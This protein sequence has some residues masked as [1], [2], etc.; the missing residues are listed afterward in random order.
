MDYIVRD[1]E[2]FS[3]TPT[4][5]PEAFWGFFRWWPGLGASVETRRRL[6]GAAV[7]V[8]LC[9]LSCVFALRPALV[10][11][12]FSAPL[13]SRVVRHRIQGHPST[14]TVARSGRHKAG[15]GRPPLSALGPKPTSHRVSNPREC[16]SARQ[17]QEPLSERS[18]PSVSPQ[19]RAVLPQRWHSTRTNTRGNIL[20]RCSATGIRPNP[21]SCRSFLHDLEERMREF[22][23][24]RRASNQNI[25]S[26]GVR[27]RVPDGQ[28]ILE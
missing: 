14:A 22:Q 6:R 4:Q 23:A 19:V 18:R 3:L 8:M 9:A 5:A 13:K 2:L 17:G 16:S 26:P 20:R 25:A 11:G 12:A 27:P 24:A 1:S 21:S 15:S 28:H 7:R 10:G